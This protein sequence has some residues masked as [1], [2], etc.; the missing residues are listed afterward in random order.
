MASHS[1]V[2]ADGMDDGLRREPLRVVTAG[3]FDLGGLAVDGFFAISGFLLAGSW[4]TG[5]GGPTGFVRR[6]FLRIYPG[7]LVCVLVCIGVVGPLAVPDVRA[8]FG[9]PHT[10]WLMK[11]LYFG[12]FFNGLPNCFPG[13]P[14]PGIIDS[15]LWTIKYEVFCYVALV[16]LGLTGLLRR[17]IV[18]GIAIGCLAAFNAIALSGRT[19]P[20]ALDAFYMPRLLT[21]FLAGAS[22]YLMRDVVPM[23]RWLLA[24][25]ALLLIATVRLPVWPTLVLPTAGLYCLLYVACIP[26]RR[27]N[28][29]GRR[30]DLSYG[31]YLYAWPLQQLTCY[32]G[33]GRGSPWVLTAAALPVTLLAAGVSWLLVE[34]PALRL[35]RSGKTVTSRATPSGGGH[36]ATPDRVTRT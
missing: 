4:M 3:H 12:R 13:N 29:F 7:F 6:R 21:F 36:F 18:A 35:K 28:T 20:F 16:C 24:A 8:Y 17:T 30:H 34:R 22:A 26:S 25:A 31:F 9:N 27:F 5:Q 1:Y 33:W 19:L 23:N 2:I 11:Y 14:I 10:Y 15:S 32:Y